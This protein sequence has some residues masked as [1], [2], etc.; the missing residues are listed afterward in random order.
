M[1]VRKLL[2]FF[3]T[4]RELK[5]LDDVMPESTRRKQDDEEQKKA[6]Y[7]QQEVSGHC[8]ILSQFTREFVATQL[9]HILS[10]RR[11]VLVLSFTFCRVLST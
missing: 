7:E 2:D 10:S 11:A 1:V 4:Q 6:E 8:H 9:A 5:I 3:F